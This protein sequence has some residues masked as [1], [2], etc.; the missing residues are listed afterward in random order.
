[1]FGLRWCPACGLWGV[2]YNGSLLHWGEDEAE[3][4]RAFGTVK[5]LAAIQ[6]RRVFDSLMGR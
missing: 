1:M 2:L 5:F 3:A 4:R 6:G